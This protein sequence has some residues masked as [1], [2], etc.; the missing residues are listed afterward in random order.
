MATPGICH[1][2]MTNCDLSIVIVHWN[3]IDL[4]SASLRSIEQREPAD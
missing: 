2:T 4:L 3:V 1:Q